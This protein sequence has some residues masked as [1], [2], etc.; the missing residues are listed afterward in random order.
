MDK[1]QNEEIDLTEF[2]N[3][4]R[5]LL[6]KILNL[7][8]TNQDKH[9]EKKELG[10]K[11]FNLELIPIFAEVFDALQEVDFMDLGHWRGNSSPILKIQIKIFSFINS[12]LY[13]L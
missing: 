12:N 2:Y 11:A 9:I 13:L 1:D 10:M 3:A 7:L 4:I 5:M 6:E 8:D